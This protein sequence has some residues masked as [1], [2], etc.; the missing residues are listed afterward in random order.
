MQIYRVK[1]CYF[2]FI[3]VSFV[4]KIGIGGGGAQ[5]SVETLRNGQSY[6]PIAPA[7]HGVAARPR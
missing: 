5:G 1:T 4:R 3:D 7:L 6:Q 2:R